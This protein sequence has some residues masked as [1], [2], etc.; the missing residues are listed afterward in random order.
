[1][2]EYTTTNNGFV[3]EISMDKLTEAVEQF[4]EHI[5]ETTTIFIGNPLDLIEIDMYEIPT[6]CYFVS[7][8]NVDKGVMYKVDGEL[9]RTLYEFIEEFPDRV[10]RG[11]KFEVFK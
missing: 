10:F 2:I 4:C 8:H 5:Y 3:S 11:K 9:K 1:M 6:N 7:N